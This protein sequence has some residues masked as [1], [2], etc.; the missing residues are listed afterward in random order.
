MNDGED[1]DTFTDVH[2]DRETYCGRKKGHKSR[3]AYYDTKGKK[4]HEF[5]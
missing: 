5:G 4:I 3:C 2:T 1:V